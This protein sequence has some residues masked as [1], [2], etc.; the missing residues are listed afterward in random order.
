MTDSISMNP[1]VCEMPGVMDRP[2]KLNNKY[3]VRIRM[4]S[5]S[6]VIFFGVIRVS[7]GWIFRVT[8]DLVA[9]QNEAANRSF[10]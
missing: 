7:P 1:P 6:K 2:K 8:T 3:A 9:H 4:I 5:T 10:Y